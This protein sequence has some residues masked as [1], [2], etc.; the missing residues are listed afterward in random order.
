MKDF[1]ERFDDWRSPSFHGCRPID[2]KKL[3]LGDKT[4]SKGSRCSEVELEHVWGVF[5]MMRFSTQARD[6]CRSHYRQ[7]KSRH[8]E[9]SGS[10]L[11]TEPET[12]VGF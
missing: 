9:Q 12:Q 2:D 6:R 7:E 10:A 5:D 3:V 11:V 4:S 8:E 1:I